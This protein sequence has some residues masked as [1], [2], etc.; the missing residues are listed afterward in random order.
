MFKKENRYVTKEVLDVV[1]VEISL[2][3]YELIEE[4]NVE[5]DYLQ[6]FK[7]NP[8]GSN[9]VEIIHKQEVPKYESTRYIYNN[10]LE[11][12]LKLYIID[13]GENS[14]LMFSYEY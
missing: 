9:V 5:I 11:E 1:P 3:L 14:T 10:K 7:L 6:I 13:N 2:L 4:L 12:K 8:I